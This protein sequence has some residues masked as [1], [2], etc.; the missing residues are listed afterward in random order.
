MADEILI[1]V[2]EAARRLAIARSHFYIQLQRGLIPSVRIGRS[3]R[4][5]VRDLEEFAV[6]QREEANGKPW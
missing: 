3:R 5:Y 6:R 1:T 2:S 4:I